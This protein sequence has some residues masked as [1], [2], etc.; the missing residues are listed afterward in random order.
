VTDSF[1]ARYDSLISG[2]IGHVPLFVAE[3]EDAEVLQVERA[4]VFPVAV[5]G[6]LVPDAFDALV[7][8]R[9]CL[10]IADRLGQVRPAYAG[11]LVYG[12]VQAFALAENAL[13][14][15]Q[16]E[17][18]RSALLAWGGQLDEFLPMLLPVLD[19]HL[20]LAAWTGLAMMATGQVLD[21]PAWS[22]K[23]CDLFRRIAAGQ[24]PGGAFRAQ[25]AADN[26]ESFWYDELVILHAITSFCVRW[27]GLI[28]LSVIARAADFH[29]NEIQ[30]DHATGEPWA[31]LAFILHEP[32]RMLADQM[33]HGVSMQFPDGVN[34]VAAILLADGLQGLRLASA[35]ERKRL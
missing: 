17:R 22:A 6:R 13:G 30:P 25:S 2:F 21:R 28:D 29:F 4:S 26:L 15:D 18:C 23:A 8:P 14:A 10:T 7:A 32:A 31:L 19:R 27:P 20:P 5:M 3:C 11:L 9:D 34:G 35:R 12:W 24:T 1:T 16:R 33:L